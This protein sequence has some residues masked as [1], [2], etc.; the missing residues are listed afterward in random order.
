[1]F[2]GYPQPGCLHNEE[3]AVLLKRK[4]FVRYAIK[5]GADLVPTFVFGASK[6]YRRIVLPRWVEWL[7]NK[8]RLSIVLFYGR[9]G[10]PVP[11]EVPLLYALGDSIRTDHY[12]RP[13]SV[14]QEVT[15]FVHNTFKRGLETVF[16]RHKNEY[17]W[18]D[19]QLKLV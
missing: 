12:G 8:F 9:L 7:S 4:G 11:Y 16:E 6:L 19:R 14:P 10:L 13:D 5:Y 17:G 3:Y 18:G 1:M 15:D 2:W